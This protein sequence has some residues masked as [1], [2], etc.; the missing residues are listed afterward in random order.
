MTTIPKQLAQSN[1][2]PSLVVAVV[3]API[4]LV[5]IKKE[6]VSQTHGRMKNIRLQLLRTEP[7]SNQRHRIQG[8]R[9]TLR[10]LPQVR[11]HR[12]LPLHYRD[13]VVQRNMSVL[14]AYTHLL[15]NCQF[16]H[17][18]LI[19]LPNPRRHTPQ[20][21]LLTF[22]LLQLLRQKTISIHHP[23]RARLHLHV[24]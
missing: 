7:P 23:L 24:T 11:L 22:Y 14:R 9:S 2:I 1:I 15:R 19:I 6:A 8:K 17:L 10:H 18:P 13:L 3:V 5:P 4:P 16:L 21:V 12:C 20:Q